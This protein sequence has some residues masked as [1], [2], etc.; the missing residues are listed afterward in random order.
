MSIAPEPAGRADEAAAAANLD[1]LEPQKRGD[2]IEAIAAHGGERAR[3]VVSHALIDAD[4]DVQLRALEQ[5]QVMQG[6]AQ[7]VDAL[8]DLPQ[9]E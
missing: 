7:P 5:T 8:R 6:L 3:E 2:A 9:L 4:E 1:Q